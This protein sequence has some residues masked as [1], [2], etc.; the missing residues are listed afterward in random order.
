MRLRHALF[1]AAACVLLP[2]CAVQPSPSGSPYAGGCVA[3]GTNTVGG[4]VIGGVGG[5]FLGRSLGGRR[6]RGTRTVVGALAG[7]AAGGLAGN[8]VDRSMPPCGAAYPVYP[9]YDPT[10]Y[11]DRPDSEPSYGAYRGY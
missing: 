1:A 4:A 7:A 6:G 8:G 9:G 3:P 10:G 11:P 2:G 5:A